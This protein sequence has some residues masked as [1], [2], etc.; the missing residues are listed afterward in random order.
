M[1]INGWVFKVTKRQYKGTIKT[2][3]PQKLLQ[4]KHCTIEEAQH[5]AKVKF[6]H[7]ASLR[8]FKK[9]LMDSIV[10]KMRS[11]TLPSTHYII[12]FD[13][14]TPPAKGIIAHTHRDK[15]VEDVYPYMEGQ[16]ILDENDN[17]GTRLRRSYRDSCAR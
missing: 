6:E 1:G 15:N 8:L 5:L 17:D 3:V 12:C 14:W 10:S 9:F 2:K 4:K 16:C 11:K 7:V 13:R